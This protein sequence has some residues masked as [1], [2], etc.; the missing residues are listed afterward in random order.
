MSGSQ[1]AR[2]FSAA[3]AEND[4]GRTAA[5]LPGRAVAAQA[6]AGSV[7]LQAAPPRKRRGSVPARLP[8]RYALA[9]R[10]SVQ[11]QPAAARFSRPR[12]LVIPAAAGAG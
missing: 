1:R 8:R 12:G 7:A 3:L 5:I 9:A 2:W 10:R 4:A 6:T 11:L